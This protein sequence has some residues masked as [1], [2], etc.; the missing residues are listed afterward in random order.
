M[1][2]IILLLISFLPIMSCSKWTDVEPIVYKHNN[3]VAKDQNAWLIYA[4]QV[5]QWKSRKHYL[6]YVRMANSPTSASSE[7]DYMRCLPDSL[8]IVSLTN[9]ENLS[10]FDREDVVRMHQLGTKVLYQLDFDSKMAELS[11]VQS[12]GQWVDSAVDIVSKENLDGWSFTGTPLYTDSFR[13]EASALIVQK[14]TSSRKQGQL[15]VFEG[16]PMFIAAADRNAIDYYVL[17]TDTATHIAE[18]KSAVTNATGYAGVSATKILLSAKISAEITD[19]S[20][21]TQNALTDLTPRVI[22][23]GPLAGIA[24]YDIASD[25]YDAYGNYPQLKKAIQTLNPAK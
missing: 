8:D 13:A 5:K 14:L 15:I 18:V 10:E 7:K 16:N 3:A 4:S 2:K 21:L 6:S 25:Y 23:L 20:K 12:L 11:D 22:N 24:V 19:E 1:K 17:A 9:A